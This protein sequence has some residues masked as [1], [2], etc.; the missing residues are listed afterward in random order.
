MNLSDEDLAVAKHALE[1]YI[2][3]YSLLEDSANDL[4]ERI[5]RYVERKAQ[6]GKNK[7]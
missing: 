7:P 5:D 2:A 4:L 6:K 1:M 3:E